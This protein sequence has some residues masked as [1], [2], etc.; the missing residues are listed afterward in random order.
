MS[1]VSVDNS[2]ESAYNII[3]RTLET[4]GLGSLSQ[5]VNDLVFKENVLDENIIRGRMRETEQYKTRFA[6]NDAR[7]KAGINVLSENEYLYLENAYRQQLRSAGMPVG[8]YD[9]NDDFTA[10]IGGDVSI[11]ELATRV[12]QGYEAVKNADPQVIQEMQRLYGVNDSQLAAYFLDPVKSTPMLVQQA[13]SAQIAAE[14]T[15]QAGLAITYQQGEQLTQAGINAEQA[16]QGFATLGQAKE[17]FNPLAGEQ[18][19]GM[20]QEEQIGS[21]FGTNAAAAQRLRKKQAERTAVFQGGGG[22]AG[23]GSGQTALA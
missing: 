16:R 21:V 13:K 20:T 14:A 7:R 18:G 2:A 22:F 5:F 11:A 15:K 9:S 19:V 8:F 3:A 12:N 4:Y 10:M 1:N 6:G 17:L 23:Q